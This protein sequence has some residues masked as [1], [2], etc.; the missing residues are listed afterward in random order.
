MSD[1][2]DGLRRMVRS[3]EGREGPPGL[4]AESRLVRACKAEQ[5]RSAQGALLRLFPAIAARFGRPAQHASEAVAADC[6]Q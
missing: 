5:K 4:A 2:A 6:S 3:L 1:Q